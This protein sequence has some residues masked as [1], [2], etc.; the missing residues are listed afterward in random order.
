[1]KIF[2]AIAGG[3]TGCPEPFRRIKENA[4]IF[5][6]GGESRHWVHTASPRKENGEIDENISRWEHD[7]SAVRC[8]EP[9]R[10]GL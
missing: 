3:G 1:M 6:V 5:S 2:L 7:I 10:G 9:D 4:D 8:P